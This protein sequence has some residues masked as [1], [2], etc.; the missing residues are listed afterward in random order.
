MKV[1]EL[2]HLD[3]SIGASKLPYSQGALSPFLS[4]ETLTF[5]YGKHYKGY[6]KKLNKLIKGTEFE[7]M[8]LEEIIKKSS[9]AK[10]T[11]VYNN[12]AQTWNHQ[13]YWKSMKHEAPPISPACNKVIEKAFGSFDD[14]KSKF[15]DE[16]TSLFGSG[17]VWLVARGKRVEILTTKNA[18]C[19]LTTPN[20]IPLFVC[21]VWEHAYYLDY[22]NDRKKYVDEFFT[23]IDWKFA[24]ENYLSSK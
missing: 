3:E 1:E 7:K 11:D 21:D 13:F 14:F 4:K 10:N 2:V 6:V 9:G 23:V 22:Q 19:P 8:E 20:V 5:H 12:A 17:W 18:D 24:E 16:A 15:I